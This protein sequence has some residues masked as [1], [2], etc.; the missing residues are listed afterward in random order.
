MRQVYGEMQIA[1]TPKCLKQN[2]LYIYFMTVL[3]LYNQKGGVGKTA[4]TVNL[5]YAS[6]LD[7]RSTLVWD[8]DPQAAA[9]YYFQVESTQKNEAKRLLSHELELPA[10]IQSTGYENLDIIASDISARNADVLLSENKLGKKRIV[11]ALKALKNQYEVIILDCPP[12]LSV[13]HDSIFQAA[14]W[15]LVPNIPTTLSMRSYETVKQ[16]FND[17]NI[18]EQKIKGFFSMVDHRKNLHHQILNEHHRDKSFFKNY[19]PYLSDVEKMG[20]QLSP[21]EVYA[22]SSY[23]AQCFRDLWK[24]IRK[25]CLG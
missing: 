22:P 5:A 25:T 18:D 1:W 10:S 24:E 17:N 2:V 20:T 13:L 16:Y 4:A 3:A 12:G 21:V 11:G 14:D 23:A 15:V 8:L 7:G 9:G 6:A 19:I